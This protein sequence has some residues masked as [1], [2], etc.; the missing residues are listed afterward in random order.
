MDLLTVMNTCATHATTATT[1]LGGKWDVAVAPPLPR[2]FCVRVFYGGER[3]PPH[4]ES[5]YTLSSQM[6]AQSVMTRAFFPVADYAKLRRRNLMLDMAAFAKAYRTAVLGDSQLG[7]AATDLVLLPA[8]TDD[9]LFG[10][11]HYGIV[12][13]EALVEYDEFD[14]AK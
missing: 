14:R 6:V 11:A 7:G 10:T 13:I 2:G 1:G 12:D 8:E 4:W 3:V 9:I 5:S